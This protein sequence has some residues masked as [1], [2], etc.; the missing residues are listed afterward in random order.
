MKGDK[1]E[2]EELLISTN[3]D[4][5]GTI[6]IG[7]GANPEKIENGDVNQFNITPEELTNI[8][9]RYKERDENMQDINYFKEKGGINFLL[10]AIATDKNKGIY[11]TNG[12]ILHIRRWPKG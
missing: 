1:E 5:H 9:N 12:F 11:S 3:S 2:K 6:Y 8:V 10:E 7:S 4:A